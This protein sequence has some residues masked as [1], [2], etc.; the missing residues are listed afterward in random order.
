MAFEPDDI[1]LITHDDDFLAHAI[2]CRVDG[3]KAWIEWIQPSLP[4]A[5]PGPYPKVLTDG[6][7]VAGLGWCEVQKVGSL[8]PSAP[9]G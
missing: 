6:G 5:A 7:Y 1:L 2:V 4:N 8:W 3:R 9:A